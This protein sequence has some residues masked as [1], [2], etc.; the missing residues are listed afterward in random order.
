AGAAGVWLVSARDDA[1]PCFPAIATSACRLPAP[2]SEAATAQATNARRL[3]RL[4]GGGGRATAR[5]RCMGGTALGGSLNTGVPRPLLRTGPGGPHASPADAPPGI[6]PAMGPPCALHRPH[7]IPFDPASGRGD[8]RV[9]H[10]GQ[11]VA[12]GRGR[13][14]CG[15]N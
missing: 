15:K 4:A 12:G 3:N 13:A 9:G 10:G 11:A 8:G 2:A 6:P 14:D 5:A 1:A 7:R